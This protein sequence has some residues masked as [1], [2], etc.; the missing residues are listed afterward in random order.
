MKNFL[1]Q[2]IIS[3]RLYYSFVT[4]VAGWLGLAYYEYLQQN[5]LIEGAPLSIWKK[6]LILFLLFVSWGIN[7][8]INDFLGLK[9]DRINAPHRPMVSGKLKARPAVLF[10]LFLML[11]ATAASLIYLSTAAAILIWVGA[12]M[13]VIY[14]FSKS[15]GLWANIVFGVMI[16]ISPL[17]GFFASA[18]KLQ[19]PWTSNFLWLV[20]GVILLNALLTYYTYFKDYKGDKAVG[21]DTLVVRLG[22]R[23]SRR[24]ALVFAMFPPVFFTLFYVQIIYSQG[25]GSVIFP[26]LAILTSM[27]HLYTGIQYFRN[28][29]GEK[30]YHLLKFNFQAGVCGQAVLISSFAP[31]LGVVLFF[32]SFAMIWILFSGYKDAKA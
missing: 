29:V 15:W 20:G 11:L 10:S 22:L 3:M 28:P 23:R 6:V 14:N 8:I 30:T 17:F 9:E 16:A 13:N 21:Q 2:Y 18:P 32:I 26:L 25:D 1:K 7:Q 27:L 24:L 4:G 31:V 19:I 5:S 12:G